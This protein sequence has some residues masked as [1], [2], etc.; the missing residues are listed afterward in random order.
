MCTLPKWPK[1]PELGRLED[2]LQEF[3]CL[4]PGFRDPRTW[5]IAFLGPRQGARSEVAQPGLNLAPTWK[6]GTT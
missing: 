3:L 2:G 6:A 4:P 1:W 5:I